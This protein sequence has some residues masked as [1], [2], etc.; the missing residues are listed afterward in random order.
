V[1][2][3][4]SVLMILLIV[5]TCVCSASADDGWSM[6]KLNPF[7]KKPAANKRVHGSVSDEAIAKSRFSPS[8][9]P[10][11]GS[12]THT[13]PSKPS[14]LTKFNQGVKDL[15]GKTKRVLM[16]WTKDSRKK[17]DSK[18]KGGSAKAKEQSILT[19]WLPKKEEKKRPR[20]L[21]EYQDLRR[22]K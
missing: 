15:Y 6:A 7:K 13:R 5:A 18:K 21:Q 4:C 16:P 17:G 1:P 3:P 12:R 14:T 19:S 9:V 2:K 22:L 8:T 11:W 20:T 10:N